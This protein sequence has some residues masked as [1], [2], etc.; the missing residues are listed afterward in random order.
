MIFEHPEAF[1]LLS[2]I[3]PGI[4]YTAAYMRKAARITQAHEAGR[5]LIRRIKTR[6]IL[7]SFAWLCAVTALADPT[8]GTEPVPVQ[9]SGNAVCFVFDIS[10]SMTARDALSGKN[11]SR[12][13]LSQCLAQNL[14]SRFNGTAVAVVLAKGDGVLAL[15]LTEDRNAAENLIRTLSPAMLSAPGSSIA[16]GIERALDAFPPQ[17]ARN[18]VIIVFTDGDETE[19]NIARA[20]KHADNFG[21]QVI[22]AGTGSETKSE[23][24]A[25][26]GKTTVQT[27]LRKA[28][29]EKAAENKNVFYISAADKKAADFM[30]PLIE[31]ASF[32]PAQENVSAGTG[33]EMQ[34][35][36]HHSLFSAF[37]IIFFIA[38]FV[39]VYIRPTK[40]TPLVLF[41]FLPLLVFFNG[42]SSWRKENGAVLLGSYHWTRRNYQKAAASFL[43]AAQQARD[44]QNEQLLHYALYG[45]GSAYLM[46]DE[47]AAAVVKFDE[48]PP[49]GA[50]AV[51]FAASY[52]KGIIA[53]RGGNFSEAA[54][55][56]KTA[57][58][59]DNSNLDAKIN[60]ELCLSQH[61]LKAKP[62]IGERTPAEAHNAP[63]GAED[64]V[65]SLIR[66]NEQK[67]W[68]STY[69]ESESGSVPDF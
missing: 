57:L 20:C 59:I 33:Y 45:L 1:I 16:A 56:F 64:A 52:N 17:S 69:T 65:F 31:P 6:C 63:P 68:K 12:L 24:L 47:Y 36:R 23:I 25:G 10:Y 60:F 29:L 18:S 27:A 51:L 26:D 61:G 8:W 9:R 46:Q 48:I 2:A 14:L 32:F 13:E 7:W 22:L 66:E 54:E 49:N 58:K 4:L 39:V 50:D 67:R 28:K 30:L 11:L 41:L 21:I 53:Y 62:A 42:C 35:R 5:F 15:P 43:T 55:C 37:G 34:K 44:T 3:P 19:G 38:G 40:K